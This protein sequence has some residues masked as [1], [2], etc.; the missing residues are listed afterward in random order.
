MLACRVY[1][2]CLFSLPS[3]RTLPMAIESSSRASV[4]G[5]SVNPSFI[6]TNEPHTL[7]VSSNV[8]TSILM[9]GR[10]YDAMLKSEFGGGSRLDAGMDRFVV[11]S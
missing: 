6:S 10:S 8:L 7:G 2:I 4:F 3:F 11:G 9:R 1:L 5:I